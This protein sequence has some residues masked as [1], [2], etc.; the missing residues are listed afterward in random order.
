VSDELMSGR[1][2]FSFVMAGL[3]PAIHEFLEQTKQGV[4]ARQ[5]RQVCA[6]CAKQTTKAGH[7]EVAGGA[8][9]S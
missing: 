7:D 5:R 8:R 1:A 6:V 3:D 9:Q 4:N 2:A